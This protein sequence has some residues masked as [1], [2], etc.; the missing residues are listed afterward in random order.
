[1]PVAQSPAHFINSSN[2][3]PSMTESFPLCC[4]LVHK[5]SLLPLARYCQWC[6]PIVGHLLIVSKYL[7]SCVWVT[8]CVDSDSGGE[9]VNYTIVFDFISTS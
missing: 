6:N 7:K 9:N 2:C 3:C 1:M 4:L 5:M 8:K